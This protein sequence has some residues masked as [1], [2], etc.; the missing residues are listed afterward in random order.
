[1]VTRVRARARSVA[2]GSFAGDGGVLRPQVAEIQRARL[3]AGAVRAIEELGYTGATVAHITRRARVSR[4]TFYELFPNREACLAAV[5]EGAAQRVRAEIA[6]AGLEGAPWRERVR[7]GLWVILS[8]FDRE[9][10]LAWVCVVQS[11]RAGQGVLERRAEILGALAAVLDEG[12][13]ESTRARGSEC[14]PL[15][16]EGLVGAAFSIVYARLLRGAPEPLGDLLG[17]LAAMI[18]LPYLGPAV[19]RREQTRAAPVAPRASVR[20]SGRGRVGSGR[21]PLEGISMR[22][23]YRTARVIEAIAEQP[24]VS[25]RGVAERAGIFDQGQISKLLARLERLGLA[26]NDGEG[27]AKGEPNAWRLT[28]TGAQV[29]QSIRVEADGAGFQHGS[30]EQGVTQMTETYPYE[31]RS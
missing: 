16:A 9:P 5:L 15:T 31:E 1:M 20:R 7:G 18:V 25:N 27:H 19:A 6:R 28:A 13:A 22:L 2:G 14:A 17:E 23:T 12:R 21:D 11:L 10:A 24:G 29:A 26:V 4:R 30:R 3:L 8:F